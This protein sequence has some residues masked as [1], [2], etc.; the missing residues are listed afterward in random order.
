MICSNCG[1]TYLGLGCRA[2]LMRKSKAAED[3]DILLRIPKIVSGKQP[4]IAFRDMRSGLR[5]DHFAVF[6]TSDKAL[7]GATLRRNWPNHSWFFSERVAGEAICLACREMLES[8]VYRATRK[9]P[10]RVTV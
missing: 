10:R 1:A 6:R 5:R 4:L 9:G 7:C 2:C 3:A 8:Y